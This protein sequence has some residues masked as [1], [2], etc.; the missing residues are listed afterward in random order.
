MENL[1]LSRVQSMARRLLITLIIIHSLGNESENGSNLEACSAWL[2]EF[3]PTRPVQYEGGRD[4]GDVLNVR[5]WTRSD[6]LTD[7]VCPMYHS[8][9]QIEST[10]QERRKLD[11]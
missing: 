9:K 7:I 10:V 2:R 8:A 3:D 11:L 5:Q 4:H 1:F 6:S